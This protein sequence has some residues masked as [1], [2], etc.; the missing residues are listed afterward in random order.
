MRS[1]LLAYLSCPSCSADLD[2]RPERSDD[3]HVLSGALVCTGCAASYPI[4]DGVPRMNIG[5]DGLQR[6]AKTFSYEWKAQQQGK[7]EKEGTLWGFT[8]EEDWRYFREATGLEDEDLVG[9]VVLDAGCGSAR[10]TRQMA[11]QCPTA[12]IGIDMNEAVEGAFAATRDLPNV[13]IVQGNIF[14]LPL[15][16]RAF[17]VVWSNGVIHHTPDAKRAHGALAEMVS[18][19]GVL[20][21]WVYAKRFNPFRF[22]KDVLDFL[23]VTRLPEPALLAVARMFAYVSAGLHAVYKLARRIPPLQPRSRWAQR[24]IRTRTVHELSLTW[25]DALSPEHDSRHSE[26][27][28]IAWFEQRGFTRVTAIEEPKVGVRGVARAM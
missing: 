21:V 7:L 2:S 1:E 26:A 27:E 24:S 14:E 12:V 28:V 16:K 5:M 3:E 22:T 6:V 4:V 13:H 20:Y 23:R 15:R 9:K 25:F 18:P 10:L 8:A 11:D 17:D 19:G